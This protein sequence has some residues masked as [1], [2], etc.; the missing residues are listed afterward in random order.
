M[1]RSLNRKINSV[2]F[3]MAFI[4]LIIGLLSIVNFKNMNLK[5]NGI[6]SDNYKSLKYLS[7]MKIIFL[8][9]TNIINNNL[10]I[11]DTTKD[12]DFNSLNEEFINWFDMQKNNITELGESEL[13]NL[14]YENYTKLLKLTKE[15]IFE[16][17]TN[18]NKLIEKINNNIDNLALINEQQMFRNKDNVL[19]YTD[20][21]IK[22][23]IIFTFLTVIFS[24]FISTVMVKNFL[25]PINI[26]TNTFKNIKDGNFNTTINYNTKDELGELITEFNNMASRI[27]NYDNMSKYQLITEK[28]KSYAIMN[29]LP[30]PIILI[31]ND[32]QIKMANKAF[33]DIFNL[34]EKVVNNTFLFEIIKNT[35]FYNF[36]SVLVKNN[37]YMVSKA[38]DFEIENKKYIYN[39]ICENI[40]DYNSKTDG[41]V[42]FF[43]NITSIKQ[44]EKLKTNIISTISHEFKTPL[45]SITLGISILAQNKLGTLN[46]KQTNI[47]N[48]IKEDSEKLSDMINDLLKVQNLKEE[49]TLYCF[50][51]VD[52]REIINKSILHF[53]NLSDLN[54]KNI[55]Y[56][57]TGEKHNIYCDPEKIELVINNLISNALKYSK[58]NYQIDIKSYYKYN[59]IF[60]EV[61]DVGPGIKNKNSLFSYENVKDGKMGLFLAKEIIELHD[62]E[63]WYEPNP[64][65]G[66]IFTFTLK[67]SLF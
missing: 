30:D 19:K 11:S 17:Y 31:D 21:I 41:I 10:L 40:Y 4:I 55:N 25:K 50:E 12:N 9:E 45:T 20:N 63:I 52:I 64:D 5:I 22:L 33:Y 8:N 49:D 23:F 53:K 1:F 14:L 27:Y 15:N 43:N 61:I 24:F 38:I 47:V 60:V 37:E 51:N 67:K 56:T 26:L 28:N 7:E 13:V 29:A 3:F 44:V 42:I 58:E 2:I 66:S 39:I 54:K 34:D 62:G 16:N 35:D 36:V 18:I 46:E 65:G 57:H 6:I 48:T 32:I 59:K